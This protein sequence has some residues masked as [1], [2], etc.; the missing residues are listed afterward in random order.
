MSFL[1]FRYNWPDGAVYDGYFYDGQ[2]DRQGT[3]KVRDLATK[4]FLVY[5]NSLLTELFSSK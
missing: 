3:Y 4:S 5:E 2:H 1:L